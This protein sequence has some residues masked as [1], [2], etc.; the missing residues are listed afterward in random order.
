MMSLFISETFLQQFGD[1]DVIADR[2]KHNGQ[3]GRLNPK[4]LAPNI[5]L[6]PTGRSSRKYQSTKRP[7][8]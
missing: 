3:Q 5:R 2:L 6:R 7:L 4:G 1:P 8:N